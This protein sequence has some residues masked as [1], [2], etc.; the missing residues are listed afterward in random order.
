MQSGTWWNN[1]SVDKAMDGNLSTDFIN[2]GSSDSTVNTGFLISPLIISSRLTGICFG[3]ATYYPFR[4]PV[5][6][7][8][9]GSQALAQS[10]ALMLGSIWTL[11]YNG[12]AGYTDFDSTSPFF[13]M[14]SINN[15]V[16]YASYRLLIT[17]QNT[18]N[19][20][21]EYSEAQLFGYIDD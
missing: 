10:S 18:P 21:S 17:V 11:L 2:H 9:E 5:W 7:A 3:S 14:Q 13:S 16:S 6:V 15:N 1:A 20:P 19:Q 12:T 8:I 4:G